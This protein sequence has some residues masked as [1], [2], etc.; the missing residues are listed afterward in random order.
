[1]NF[2]EIIGLFV[3][4]C[5]ISAAFEFGKEIAKAQLMKRTIN[6]SVDMFFTSVIRSMMKYRLDAKTVFK[7]GEDEIE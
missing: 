6:Q 5:G 4:F 2:I 7:K 3:C 1:M